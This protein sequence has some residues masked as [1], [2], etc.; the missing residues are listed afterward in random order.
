MWWLDEYIYRRELSL[1]APEHESVP[2]FHPV[3]VHLDWV[4]FDNGKLRTDF[5]DVEVVFHSDDESTHLYREVEALESG[6]V[7]RFQLVAGLTE[8]T[9]SDGEY[10]VYYG[11]LDV[12][13]VPN[14]PDYVTIG[15]TDDEEKPLRGAW[16]ISLTHNDSLI[17][18][19]RPGEHWREGVSSHPLARATTQ[20]YCNKFR[21]M[22]EVGLEYGMM[23]VQ[24]DGGA[25]E[26]VN[27][28]RRTPG[29]I[30][31]YELDGLD[32]NELHEIRIRVM[33]QMSPQSLD[34]KVNVK[35]IE[36]SKPVISSDVGEQVNDLMWSSSLG[37][38]L[39]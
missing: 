32:P 18:Y 4:L 28:Y 27:L 26:E 8:G 16:P 31:V 17:A 1:R 13:N 10:Y 3:E 25:W 33:G 35:S 37:G 38:G 12:E 11:N 36:Y 39:D 34:S 22:S 14:R 9:I 30:A 5:A 7:V 19:T 2:S 21:I 23:E 24:V 29:I 20:I 15:V 6:L